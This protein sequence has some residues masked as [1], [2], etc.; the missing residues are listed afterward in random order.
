[1]VQTHS[2]MAMSAQHVPTVVY[3][4]TGFVSM[5][6]AQGY[7]TSQ[8]VQQSPYVM[9]HVLQSMQQVHMVQQAHDM[10]CMLQEY[11]L[12]GDNFVDAFSL[13]QHQHVQCSNCNTYEN[14][15]KLLHSYVLHD[16]LDCLL[17]CNMCKMVLPKHL[18]PANNECCCIRFDGWQ[19]KLKQRPAQC[20]LQQQQQQQQGSSHSANYS[21]HSI[22]GACKS[23]CAS[24]LCKGASEAVVCRL[25]D[26]DVELAQMA[27]AVISSLNDPTK[28]V[29]IDTCYDST[30][31]MCEELV[32]MANTSG[33]GP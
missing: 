25:A 16:T 12:E 2:L 26:F 19:C 9:Q 28:L 32:H 15:L 10:Q 14:M 30:F 18:S 3:S 5:A 24:C 17:K 33:V 22:T 23:G 31:H 11:T 1:M 27:S 13:A 20:P 29:E 7:G 6:G 8:L 4:P 21:Q